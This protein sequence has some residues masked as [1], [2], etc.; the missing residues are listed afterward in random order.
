MENEEDKT[1]IEIVQETIKQ[2]DEVINN[3]S[4]ENPNTPFGIIDET[5]DIG[6]VENESN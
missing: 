3:L 1:L 6:S 2:V 4:D 5:D